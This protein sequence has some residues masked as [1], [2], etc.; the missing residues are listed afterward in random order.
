MNSKTYL[1]LLFCVATLVVEHA[2]AA[3]ILVITFFSSKSHKLTY[4]PLI[5]ELGK[6]G[7]NITMV[8]PIKPM[9]E[10]K[11]VKEIFTL[12]VE[13]IFQS[14]EF[15]AFEAK[16]KQKTIEPGK[17]V[18]MIRD[19]CDQSYDLPQV[20]SLL[21]ENFDLVFLQP[22]FNDCILGLIY[23]L[24][25]PL[26]LFTPTVIPSIIVEKVGG[27][28]PS[29][30]NPNFILGYSNPM[31]FM[32]RFKNFGVDLMATAYWNFIYEPKME[33]VY[34]EKLGNDIPSVS[35]IFADQTSLVLSNGHF[36]LSGP[37][38]YYPDVIDVGGIHSKP[39]KPIPKVHIKSNIK[40]D[41]K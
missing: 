16:Q 31:N 30:L 29:S 17:M 2:N 8:S 3:N 25:A 4:T 32:E 10:M 21:K 34:R 41:S 38:P 19:T 6:R 26:V 9:K 13:K 33:Q 39:A 35:E 22:M 15:D 24:Q 20:Q 23:R 18:E 28:F 7:H 14:N 5:E 1:V 11:N 27:N 40:K 36:S 37:N 12:D